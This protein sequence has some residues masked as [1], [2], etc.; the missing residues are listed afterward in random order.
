MNLVCRDQVLRNSVASHLKEVFKRVFARKVPEEVNEIVFALPTS[1]KTDLTLQDDSRIPEVLANNL[2][3]LQ[4]IARTNSANVDE[5]P[6][7][8]YKLTNT[9]LL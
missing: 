4:T 5:V 6:S 1:R 9:K 8:A 3:T 7:L 2:K